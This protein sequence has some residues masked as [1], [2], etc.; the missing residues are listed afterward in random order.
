[1][2]ASWKGTKYYL[3]EEMCRSENENK[4]PRTGSEGSRNDVHD[5]EICWQLIQAGVDDWRKGAQ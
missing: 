1:L 5:R 4:V 3:N 2:E